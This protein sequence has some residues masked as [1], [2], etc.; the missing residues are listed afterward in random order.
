MPPA[1]VSEGVP[2]SELPLPPDRPSVVAKL[3]LVGIIG[4]RALL[5][6]TDPMFRAENHFPPCISLGSGEQLESVSVIDV[7]PHSIVLEEDGERQTKE[8]PR[9]R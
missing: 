8:L 7:T 6:F 1:P 9:I 2:I 4:D 3:K 5:T